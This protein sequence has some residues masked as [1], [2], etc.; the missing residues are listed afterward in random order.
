[1]SHVSELRW[2]KSSFSGDGG[3][4]CVEI[5]VTGPNTVALRDSTRPTRITTMGQ[6]AFQTLISAVRAGRFDP[7]QT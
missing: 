3:N 1:M 6:A 7:I 2:V 4:N 5:A